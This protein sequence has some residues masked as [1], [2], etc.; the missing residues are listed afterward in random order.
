MKKKQSKFIG[1]FISPE[2]HSAFRVKAAREGR[3]ICEITSELVEKFVKE[4]KPKNK[5]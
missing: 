5:A 1:A 4:T 2:I 3:T